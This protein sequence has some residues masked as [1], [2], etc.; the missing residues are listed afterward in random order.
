MTIRRRRLVAIVH[1][2]VKGYSSLMQN[3]EVS[4]IEELI[5]SQSGMKSLAQKH[6]G[7]VVD[8]AG[9]GFLLEF[10][11]A[12][13]A[14]QFAL[15]FQEAVKA[16]NS[17][18]PKHRQMQFR[19]G[20]NLGRVTE[21]GDKIY[22]NAVNIAARLEG[23]ATPGS[24]CISETVYNIVKKKLPLDYERLAEQALKNI[25]GSTSAYRIRAKSSSEEGEASTT[26]EPKRGRKVPAPE[27]LL[28]QLRKEFSDK[29]RNNFLRHSLDTIVIYFQQGLKS[30]SKHDPTIETGFDAVTCQKYR[31]EVYRAGGQK[32]RC[33]VWISKL[34]SQKNISYRDLDSGTNDDSSMNEWI[35]TEDDGFALY[36]TGL[37]GKFGTNLYGSNLTTE[38]A[39]RVLWERFTS[40]LRNK[41]LA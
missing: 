40:P 5:V 18:V 38:E 28:P 41:C 8:T 26:R 31:F 15:D 19:I 10:V 3:D 21:V 9:D 29:D 33:Q 17:N 13:D 22:G 25:T 27:M 30:L 4:T 12:E 2:D 11:T 34:G 39:A 36:L 20:I 35:H 37:M 23:L 14:V 16:Q 1:A 24:I 6:D 32:N 7:H